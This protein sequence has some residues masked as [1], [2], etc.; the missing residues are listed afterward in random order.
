MARKK[1]KPSS[2]GTGG[3][4][5]QRH[6][7][8]FHSGVTTGHPSYVYGEDGKDYKIVGITDSPITKGKDNIPLDCNPEP[9]N[10][11]KAYLRPDPLR[12]N[13]GEKNRKLKGWKFAGS[14]KPKVDKVIA[15]EK[16]KKKKK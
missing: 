14:D 8:K 2:N 9:N 13:K 12:V 1:K 15:S 4:H 7:R 11:D 10:T 5:Y 16:S 6:F 3:K